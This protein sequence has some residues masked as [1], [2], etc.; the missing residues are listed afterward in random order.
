MAPAAQGAGCSRTEEYVAYFAGSAGSPQRS[1]AGCQR[2]RMRKLFLRGPLAISH[3]LSALSNAANRSQKS[4]C[5][6]IVSRQLVEFRQ[7]KRGRCQAF[8]GLGCAPEGNICLVHRGKR[9]DIALPPSAA[10]C[11][12]FCEG[13]GGLGLHASIVTPPMLGGAVHTVQLR[14]PSGFRRSSLGFHR[15][16][17]GAILSWASISCRIAVSRP[18]RR[19]RHGTAASM[20]S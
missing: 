8:G 11:S 14:D 5:R 7:Q 1:A 2:V 12:S 13:S 17:G 3:Q 20:A 15:S 16:L 4:G 9:G 19:G 18:S 10:P 6:S